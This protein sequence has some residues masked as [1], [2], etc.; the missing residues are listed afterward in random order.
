MGDVDAK[1]VAGSM[2]T[3]SGNRALVACCLC[4]VKVPANDANMCPRCLQQQV[5][6]VKDLA[7][8]GDLVFC[9]ECGRSLF[10]QRWLV[11]E[12]ESAEFLSLCVKK[13][14]GLT[15]NLK[16]LD[17]KFVWTEPH[18]KRI[19]VSVTVQAE[20]LSNV[21]VKQA[22]VI[23]FK[24]VAQ[25]CG[26]CQKSSMGLEWNYCMQVRQSCEGFRK[27]FRRLEQDLIKSAMD[28]HI[29]S[30]EE[31][32]Q[33]FDLW[34][35][36]RGDMKIVL[37][38]LK[39]NLPL[40]NAAQPTK[41][42]STYTHAVQIAPLNKF[43][44]V[45]VP[46]GANS[47]N[48][49]L[50]LLKRITSSLHFVDV[51]T[52]KKLEMSGQAYWKYQS[53]KS[54]SSGA[55]TA[56]KGKSKGRSAASSTGGTAS[57]KAV[58]NYAT[59]LGSEKLTEFIVIDVLSDDQ[60]IQPVQGVTEVVVAR[61]SD[62]GSNDQTFIVKTYLTSLQPGDS[63]LGYDLSLLNLTE[64][65]QEVLPDDLVEV[66]LVNKLQKDAPKKK[67]KALPR[68]ARVTQEAEVGSTV[69]GD[70]EDKYD[71]DAAK[72]DIED[73]D[74]DQPLEPLED[75]HNIISLDGAEI[76]PDDDDFAPV[77]SEEES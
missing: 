14:K 17:A 38:W 63:V 31:K 57:V 19:K 41:H 36:S 48:V 74:D 68:L 21:M 42:G 7:P 15:K 5:N 26:L 37:D 8:N 43:D 58:S 10:H 75:V 52:G 70:D 24:Q 22:T 45:L 53:K 13:I 61:E 2:M 32:A 6:I 73:M 27:T 16:L 76:I 59:L 72:W 60:G 55:A 18:S 49:R 77:D 64:A 11:L 66:M 23:E 39:S 71:Q 44:L 9:Q 40:T 62:F 34:F 56:T 28:K 25:M 20:V 1:S 3:T 67:R 46:V 35:A 51:V 4:G 65:H 54:S 29:V 47:T 50:M 12:P 30:V 33:G 69:G